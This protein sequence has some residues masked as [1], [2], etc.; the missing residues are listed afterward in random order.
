M[1]R[2]LSAQA[3]TRHEL[4]EALRA[5]EVP[6]DAAAVVL[7]R[8][9]E[10]GLVDDGAFA[11]DWVSSRQQRRHLSKSALRRE[12]QTRGV[13]RDQIDQALSAVGT[14]DEYAA[15]LSL[16]ERKYRT[17]GELSREVAY[18]R[19]SGA[20]GRRGFSGGVAARVLGEVLGRS[21]DL[22]SRLDC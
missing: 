17:M 15:A 11:V 18:R 12:L 9:E 6:D 20:L 4:A 1:L 8:M 22:R 5:K 7:D 14:D 19:L 16:A 10:V 2:K 13:D 3:R 21:E